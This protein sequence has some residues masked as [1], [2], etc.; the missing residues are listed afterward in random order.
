MLTEQQKALNEI[1]S[2]HGF[3]F[4]DAFEVEE[5]KADKEDM[6]EKLQDRV[7]EQ[8][9][10]YYSKAM[11]YL[12]E[13]DASLIESLGLAQELGYTAGKLNSELLATL[14]YQQNLS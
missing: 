10:I 12:S 6:F 3:D 4:I 14:L 13:N 7:N 1:L 2:S 8:D 11:E 5:W 9:I